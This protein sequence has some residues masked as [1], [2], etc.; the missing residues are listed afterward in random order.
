[1][2]RKHSKTNLFVG[3]LVDIIYQIEILVACRTGVGELD[4]W[5]L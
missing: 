4:F 1:M 5:K 3:Q 2:D